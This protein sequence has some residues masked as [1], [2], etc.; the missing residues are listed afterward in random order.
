MTDLNDKAREDFF[1]EAQE[2]IEELARNLLSLDETLRQGKS[3]PSLINDAF[4]A[5]HTLKGLS[6][7]FGA[8]TMTTLAHRLE[9]ILDDLRLGR[10]ALDANVL[11]VLFRSVEVFNRVLAVEKGS[12]DE[13]L[14]FVDELLALIQQVGST[15]IP[16][17]SPGTDYD[18]DPGML[19]VLTEYEEHRLHA[20]L[21]EGLR[22]FRLR[23]RFDLATIDKSLELI[24]E[25]AKTLG[26]IITYLPTGEASGPDTIDLD[27][28]MA[29]SCD[30]DKIESV[31]GND[32]TVVQE[33]PRRAAGHEAAK[34]P[35]D[36]PKSRDNLVPA[37]LGTVPPRPPA[38]APLAGSGGTLRS[39]SQSVRVDIRKLDNLMNIV[40]ELAI[41][42]GAI[43]RLS[44]RLRG[45]GERRASNE[46]N[47]LNRSFERRLSELQESILEVRMVPLGQVFDRLARVVRQIGREVSKDIRLVITGSETEIDKLIVEEL[48][49][50]LMHMI[51][52]AI[53]HGI[54]S[55]EERSAVGKPASGTIA[56]NAF[57][58]GNHVVLEVEDDGRGIDEAAIVR[59]AVQLGKLGEPQL[60]ELSRTEIL[61]LIFLPGLST[62]E[63]AGELS[64][65]GVGMDIVKTNIAKLGG[66]IDVLSE[67][68]I[69]T[70]MTV[71]LPITLA[72]VSALLVCVGD[73]TMAIPLASVSEAIAFDGGMVRNIDGREV[74]TLRGQTLPV[75]RLDDF[76]DIPREVAAPRRQFA[77]VAALGSRKIGLVVDRMIGQQD[78][79]IKALGPSL[80]SARSFAGATELGDQ[81]VGLVLDAP[82]ILEEVLAGADPLNPMLRVSHG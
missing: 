13:S 9:D 37:A 29:C 40:G 28:L 39:V 31:L 14:G 4:R 63:E 78:I 64:G 71:T 49:D 44:D 2:I 21:K 35:I 69:G 26:E 27:L 81:R 17:V 36:L 3:D 46:L 24:K 41:V 47:R 30:Q 22:L 74:M 6:S 19:A 33:V 43:G 76:F 12:I 42:R 59:K 10:M 34:P 8:A 5:V 23:I 16:P 58:K 45:T 32:N 68:G 57:Q 56:L 61:S 15:S 7:L 38:G 51:R 52:N 70:K 79:V 62:C 82:A 25:R 50:P 1:S 73:E 65:R 66:V 53:D 77:V 75:C 55:A 67:P 72:I 48:S 18:L 54:E 80:S 20:N 60:G 11:D